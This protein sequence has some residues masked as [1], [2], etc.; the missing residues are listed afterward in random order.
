[1]LLKI[2][3]ILTF[4]AQRYCN[5]VR[6]SVPVNQS[7]SLLFSFCVEQKKLLGL[8]GFHLIVAPAVLF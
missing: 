5:S 3:P 6:A 1:M 2:K 8:S 7:V 4:N